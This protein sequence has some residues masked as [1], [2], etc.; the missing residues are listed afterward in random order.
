MAAPG[1][2]LF[3]LASPRD[4]PKAGRVEDN[5]EN[6]VNGVT[7]PLASGSVRPGPCR[8]ARGRVSAPHRPARRTP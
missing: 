5:K 8:G 4:T 6:A 3:A 7:D 1:A 2:V